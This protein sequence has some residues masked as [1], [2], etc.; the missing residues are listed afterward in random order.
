ML[1]LIREERL[2]LLPVCA[3][4]TLPSDVEPIIALAEQS[5][6]AIEASV[7]IG[8]SP[9]RWRA[10]GWDL[11]R[12]SKLTREAVALAARAGLPVTFVTEDTTRTPP[13]RCVEC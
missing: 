3:G 5:G 1:R 4:R 2:P 11:E 13:T 8:A 10:E 9:I 7:F 6:I 12:V